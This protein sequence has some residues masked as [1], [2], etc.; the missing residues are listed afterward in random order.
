MASPEI[1][2][3]QNIY[4]YFSVLMMV[5]RNVYTSVDT[6]NVC[7]TD[8]K[9]N[10]LNLVPNLLIPFNSNSS[11]CPCVY[12]IVSSLSEFSFSVNPSVKTCLN[13]SF[14]LWS[15]LFY[16]GSDSI[17]LFLSI[18]SLAQPLIVCL[19]EYFTLL[20]FLFLSTKGSHSRQDKNNHTES[21]FLNEQKARL[22]GLRK[23][24]WSWAT[25]A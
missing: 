23:I 21:G 1:K 6:T 24:P 9:K 13:F 22:E 15:Y 17:S 14:S 2:T 10:N 8:K 19:P 11:F 3:K 4:T 20:F 7:Y 12:P 18:S 16:G 5:C 25:V